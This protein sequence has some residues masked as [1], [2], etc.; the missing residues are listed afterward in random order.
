M[1]KHR[2]YYDTT[3][4][5]VCLWNE[6]SLQDAMR[7]VFWLLAVL[8]VA[9]VI[10]YYRTSHSQ[11][12]SCTGDGLSSSSG[13]GG[14]SFPSVSDI[15]IILPDAHDLVMRLGNVMEPADGDVG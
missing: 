2:A 10:F 5:G 1:G 4:H 14:W 11:E 3:Q 8:A 13:H 15:Q 7:T 12:S 9:G 6:F